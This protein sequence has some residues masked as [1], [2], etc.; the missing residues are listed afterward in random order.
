MHKKA[1]IAIFCVL[2]LCAGTQENEEL[3]IADSLADATTSLD[4]IRIE[5]FVP[6]F[7]KISLDFAPDNS[8]SL[9]GYYPSEAA[10][11]NPAGSSGI[12]QP[13]GD[14]SFSIHPGTVVDLGLAVLVSNVVGPYTILVYSANGGRLVGATGGQLVGADGGPLPSS[15]GR[16]S[17]DTRGGQLNSEAPDAVVSIPYSLRLD[18]QQCR[19]Q[20]GVFS[21]AGSGKSHSGGIRLSVS[22]VFDELK[23]PLPHNVYTD[24][25]SFVVSAN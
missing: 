5:G 8:A 20:G 25:L 17:A 18:N 1:L 6:D 4:E 16:Q 19:A 2:A 3:L 24:E 10:A 22:L 13:Q 21:F 12:P 15:A 11:N 9:V 7:L 23:P 14:K